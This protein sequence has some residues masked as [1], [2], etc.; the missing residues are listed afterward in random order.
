MSDGS[1]CSLPDVQASPSSLSP[2]S[3]SQ[4]VKRYSASSHRRSFSMVVLQE[5][6]AGAVWAEEQSEK[7]RG[8]VR[9]KMEDLQKDITSAER[10][11]E[12]CEVTPTSP[13][14]LQTCRDRVSKGPVVQEIAIMSEEGET[15][16]AARKVGTQ[17]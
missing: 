11:V 14:P 17:S 8:A 7:D 2:S 1:W 6:L 13:I 16:F 9:L 5:S 3:K 12:A 4:D 10:E 15:R